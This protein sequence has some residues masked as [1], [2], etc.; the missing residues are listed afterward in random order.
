MK[1]KHYFESQNDRWYEQYLNS[2]RLLSEL[3]TVL[4]QLEVIALDNIRDPAVRKEITEL[5]A[6]IW[7]IPKPTE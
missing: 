1:M 5:T 4:Y 3:E 6:S 7:R 2:E